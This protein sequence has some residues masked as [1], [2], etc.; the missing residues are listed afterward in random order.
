MATNS[1]TD[2]DG[3]APGSGSA[4]PGA[5]VLP[6]W[7]HRAEADRVKNLEHLLSGRVRIAQA[8]AEKVNA[9]LR[10]MGIEPERPAAAD[11]SGLLVP[12][13]L[14]DADPGQN[15]YGVHATWDEEARGVTL[16][17]SD[18]SGHLLPA[19]TLRRLADV[20]HARHDGPAQNHHH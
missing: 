6:A 11:E 14:V 19:R 7:L 5:P 3:T 15:L 13:L 1:R 10:G 18:P 9:H 20:A 4:A 17:V 8:N 12:A 2:T 16:L